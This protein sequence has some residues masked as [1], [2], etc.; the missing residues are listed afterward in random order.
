MAK[1]NKAVPFGYSL[2]SLVSFRLTFYRSIY[3]ASTSASAAID[4]FV[5]VDYI[6]TFAFGDSF[7]RTF[8]STC[9]TADASI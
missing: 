2:I 3:R 9:A 1:E 4:A 6:C 5:C 7:Y 8:C